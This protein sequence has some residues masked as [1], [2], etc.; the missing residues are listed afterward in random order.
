VDLVFICDAYHHFEYPQDTLASLRQ[1]L[2]RRGK[3]VLVEFH[4]EDGRS[5]E[6]ILRH[7][8]A[9][10]A[11]FEAEI[12]SAGFRKVRQSGF[13]RDNYLVVFEKEVR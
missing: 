1:A 12:A 11:V 10:Q 4:R 9:G 7:V 5:S 2:R 8:R 6:W 13:L 3:L